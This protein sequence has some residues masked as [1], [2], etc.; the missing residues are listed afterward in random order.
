M[1]SLLRPP[2][3]RHIGPYSLFARRRT[4]S[5][6]YSLITAFAPIWRAITRATLDDPACGEDSCTTIDTSLYST[7]I[8]VV[9]GRTALAGLHTSLNSLD[10][11]AGA[12]PLFSV[13]ILD[14][15]FADGSG[16]RVLQ[17]P[18]FLI[19]CNANGSSGSIVGGGFCFGN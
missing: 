6:S 5:T 19:R 17:G 11:T 16:N 12:P 14:V 9:G 4:V 1:N 15:Y 8:D 3:A 10:L 18:A 13:E 2:I 7:D